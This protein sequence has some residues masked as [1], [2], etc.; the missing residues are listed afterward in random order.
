MSFSKCVLLEKRGIASSHIIAKIMTASSDKNEESSSSADVGK[1]GGV[2]DYFAILGVG[3]KL[4]WKHAQKKSAHEVTDEQED[5]AALVE[6]FYREIVEVAIV[7]TEP[8]PRIIGQSPSMDEANELRS[9]LSSSSLQH[10]QHVPN[11]PCY[12]EATTALTFPESAV[13]PAPVQLD[14]FTVVQQTCPAGRNSQQDSASLGGVGSANDSSMSA[15][16]LDVSRHGQLWA[17][18]QTFDANLDP[19][20]GLRAEL[21]SKVP[22]AIETRADGDGRHTPLKGLGRKLGTSLRKLNHIVDDRI[23]HHHEHRTK[24]HIGYRRRGPDETDKPAVADLSLRYVRIHKLTAC[25]ASSAPD[26]E[27]SI[28]TLSTVQ[29]TRTAALKRSLATGAVLAARVAEAGKHKLM[30]KYRHAKDD[31]HRRRHFLPP[32]DASSFETAKTSGADAVI[33]PLDELVPVPIGFDEWSIPEEYKWLRLTN[34]SS[35]LFSPDREIPEREQVAVSKQHKTILISHGSAK[36]TVDSET[37]DNSGVGVEAY[38]ENAALHLF[39][40][41]D[42]TLRSATWNALQRRKYAIGR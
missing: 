2:A 15:T 14:G 18:A 21:S 12:S 26:D 39:R 24:F 9:A 3:E 31:E 41:R 10:R 17:K 25:G 7:A 33:V 20:T 6:R 1:R 22:S 16:D 40:Q 42:Q 36:S 34:P 30:E 32:Q 27:S 37:S 29:S 13:A 28:A 35:S 5:E 11:S 8:R 23:R 4:V 38:M 19:V